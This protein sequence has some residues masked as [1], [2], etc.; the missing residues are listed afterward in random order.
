M[1]V[2]EGLQDGRVAVVTKMHH[3]TMDG[4]TGADLMAHLFDLT[5]EPR[6]VEPPTAEFTGEEPPSPVVLL[7]GG[8]RNQA[9]TPLRMARQVVKSTGGVVAAAKSSL[10]QR[11]K[12]TL[13]L[14]APR[15][16]WS[17]ALSSQRSVGLT[18]IS[19]ADV[20]I[21]KDHHGVK[22]NDVLLAVTTQ[23]LRGYLQ[24][25]Q[26]L[27]DKPLVCSVPISVR[28]EGDDATNQIATML[29]PLPVQLEDPVEQLTTIAAA[30]AASKELTS[31]M[32]TTMVMDWS[33]LTAPTL[34]KAFASVYSG[35]RLG[36]MHPPL[37]NA[38]VS[39]AQ[40]P[41]LELYVAGGKVEAVYP[42]GPLL[43]GA[44]INVTVR[45]TWATST[46][47]S[48]PMR[49]R[50]RTCGVSPTRFP[51][52]WRR[53]SPPCRP[54]GRAQAAIAGAS[55]ASTSSMASTPAG[56]RT[57]PVCDASTV[58]NRA[59]GSRV[60]LLATMPSDGL[61]MPTSSTPAGGGLARSR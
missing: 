27:P 18:T 45:S 23:A 36:A 50:F 44:G 2:V 32:G 51:S 22:V 58:T 42:M 39:N 43:P 6:D 61:P 49:P 10:Q 20:K 17:G 31:A 5:P 14:T 34:I 52:R 25:R 30:T 40:G 35:L 54:S 53:C 16:P 33:E 59:S 4:V 21:V 47:G 55:A 13:P 12:A 37:H 8:L 26:L 46:R 15:V 38:V 24:H 41:P 7:A 19:L 11:R 9:A 48:S 29:A 1:W 28:T 60:A 3:S 56:P 57:S